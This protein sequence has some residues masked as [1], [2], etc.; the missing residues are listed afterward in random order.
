MTICERT[1]R[2]PHPHPLSNSPVSKPD[3]RSGTSGGSGTSPNVG[4]GTTLGCLS[5]RT[6]AIARGDPVNGGSSRK[7]RVEVE[8]P[9]AMLTRHVR[10][11]T[12]LHRTDVRRVF[13]GDGELC[14]GLVRA[15]YE[16]VELWF[17]FGRS[18]VLDVLGRWNRGPLPCDP[19]GVTGR[20]Q[21]C[22]VPNSAHQGIGIQV[23][24]S[25]AP[26]IHR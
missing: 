5:K 9:T 11:G 13:A 6:T 20:Q 16:T 4:P 10:C 26:P 23:I 18:P 2:G 12:L 7:P 25:G 14:D 15:K 24:G 22:P 17:A 19:F 21:P 8:S 3:G 1:N